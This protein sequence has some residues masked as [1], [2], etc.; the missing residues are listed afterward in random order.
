LNFTLV[1]FV[2]IALI[3]DFLNGFHDSAN[4]V[5]TA[6]ASRAMSPKYALAMT[7]I[8]N[9]VGPF[10]FGVAVATTIGNEVVLERAVTIPVAMA[11][12]LSAIIWNILT[13]W[14]GIPSSS[15]H[16]LIGG[17][18]G[19]AIAGFGTG[20]IQLE[21]LEKVSI[22]LFLSPVIG[23]VF[24]FIILRVTLFFAQ[25]AS[26]SIT[27]FFR[28]SQWVTALVLALS[29]GTND[30]QKTMGIIALG[31]VAFGVLPKFTVPTW[32]IAASALAIALGTVT[33]GWRLI[34]TMGAGFFRVR[35]IHALTSQIASATVILGAAL[36]GTP[37]STTQVISSSIVGTGAS[38]RMHKVRWGVAG[39]IVLAW[40]LTIPS[41][42]FLG[43][44]FYLIFNR[45]YQ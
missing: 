1:I 18:L 25:W 40:L 37:V 17:F 34:R 41:T 43:A 15:S 28:K 7:A 27:I 4:V 21:G 42:G 39:N 8:A 24:G 14:F 6:I 36:M 33:G 11:A 9:F 29:H 22:G 2:A 19:A 23:F 3:F 32:V 44:I 16:A 35:A 38:E 45:I 30:A 10:L 13:W 12:L 31:L 5:A 20:V 26:P